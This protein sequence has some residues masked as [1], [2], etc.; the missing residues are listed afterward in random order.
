MPHPEEP[1]IAQSQARDVLNAFA[2][3]LRGLD[4][5]DIHN[6]NT[7]ENL[8]KFLLAAKLFQK[9]FGKIT[10]S[11]KY[12]HLYCG[13][14]DVKTHFS[15]AEAE[16]E[17]Q[18]IF[19]MAELDTIVFDNLY[20]TEEITRLFLQLSNH[21]RINIRPKKFQAPFSKIQLNYLDTAEVIAHKTSPQELMK[22]DHYLLQYF[23]LAKLVKLHVDEMS[24]SSPTHLKC[25]L[26]QLFEIVR[27]G[28]NYPLGLLIMANL[29]AGIDPV[30]DQTTRTA[31]LTMAFAQKIGFSAA[32]TVNSGLLA[33]MYQSSKRFIR[34]DLFEKAAELTDSD[35]KEIEKAREALIFEF[36][37]S[38]NLSFRLLEQLLNLYDV[39]ISEAT[40]RGQVK[41]L[42]SRILKICNQYIALITPKPFRDGFLPYEALTI[43]QKQAAGATEQ[44]I[45]QALADLIGYYP[46][47]SLVML[48]GNERAV[49]VNPHG[50]KR[51]HPVVRIV[52]TTGHALLRQVD[53][54][55]SGQ[56]ITAFLD[57]DKEQVAVSGHLI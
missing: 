25:L 32:E 17:L 39:D 19:T 38:G 28:Q 7:R 31:I 13:D 53:T 47:G 45:Y 21:V 46:I 10:L 50:Q 43:L 33:I 52:E 49:V 2:A 29:D 27:I 1:E 24:T 4:V 3:V 11:A 56:K 23:T 22:P 44:L 5:H 42:D 6:E 12:G 54:A 34:K 57:P 40:K 14:T 20:D 8:E 18:R 37:K 51:N 35:R 15:L 41:A 16:K 36:A 30:L 9:T 26:R 55:V 48:E